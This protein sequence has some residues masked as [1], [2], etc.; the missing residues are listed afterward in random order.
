MRTNPWLRNHKLSWDFK[1]LKD[2]KDLK[3]FKDLK[4][5]KDLSVLKVLM[6]ILSR[7]CP[8]RIKKKVLQAVA[9]R[10]FC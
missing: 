8:A 10:T 4:N 6:K 9:Q 3:D 5:L 1:D 2:L 7:P